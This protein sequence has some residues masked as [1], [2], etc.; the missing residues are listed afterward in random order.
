MIPGNL[1]LYIC[2]KQVR[3]VKILQVVKH[4]HPDPQYDDAVF[5]ASDE[6]Q[7]GH[8]FYGDKIGDNPPIPVTTN[9]Y[10]KH[11]PEDGGYYVIYEDGYASYSPAKAFEAGYTAVPE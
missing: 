8:I 4:A 5:E 7:G 10:R 11:D 9:W 1:P 3:A 6:F 2:H